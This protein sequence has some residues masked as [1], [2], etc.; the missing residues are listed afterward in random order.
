MKSLQTSSKVS[1]HLNYI[2]TIFWLWSIKH[3]IHFLC[4][5]NVFWR[6]QQTDTMSQIAIQIKFRVHTLIKLRWTIITASLTQ[7][8][9]KATI[10]VGRD[11]C[12]PADLSLHSPVHVCLFLNYV[13]FCSLGSCHFT[14]IFLVNIHSISHIHFSILVQHDLHNGYTYTCG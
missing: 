14:G 8:D 1:I 9:M 2:T 4:I 5:Y 6:R 12:T 7:Y 10:D 11:V 13:Y 3:T